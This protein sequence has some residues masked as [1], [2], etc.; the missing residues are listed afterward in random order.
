MCRVM[1]LVFFLIALAAAGIAQTT[2]PPAQSGSNAPQTTNPSGSQ[3]ANQNQVPPAMDQSNANSAL[4]QTGDVPAN[5]E[6]RATL[7][8]PLSSR[9]SKPGDRFTATVSQPVQGRNEVAIPAGTRVEG[10]VSEAEQDKAIPAL[11]GKGTLNLRFRDLVLPNGQTI[12]LVASLVSVN[13]T[14]GRGTQKADNEGQM[15]SG[16]QGKSV[17]K[18]VGVGAG[19]AGPI[20]GAPLTGLAIGALS[21][22][23]YVLA[24]NGKDVTLPA[25]T[26]MVIRLD[27][28]LNVQ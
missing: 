6:M 12:P 3:P 18:D 5:T 16:T 17:A 25:Q 19:A 15:E 10:E 8:T 26:G 14:N 24:R 2:A 20:F 23:G 11:R 21:G 28:P 1:M 4:G 27:Q 13:R 7:D 9:T 22:G